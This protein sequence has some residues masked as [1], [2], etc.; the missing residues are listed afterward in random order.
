MKPEK[1]GT[2]CA[3]RT[4]TGPPGSALG[5]VPRSDISDMALSTPARVRGYKALGI[6]SIQGPRWASWDSGLSCKSFSTYYWSEVSLPDTVP[7][8]LRTLIRD[9]DSSEGPLKPASSRSGRTSK[10]RV[11][12]RLMPGLSHTPAVLLRLRFRCQD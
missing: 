6:E 9:A 2:T 4:R 11:T 5:A 3:L 7:R 8:L 10:G 12:G 1:P